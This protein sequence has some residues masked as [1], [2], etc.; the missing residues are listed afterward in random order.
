MPRS[1]HPAVSL[2]TV[3]LTR[4]ESYG[5]SSL[6]NV[7]GKEGHRDHQHTCDKWGARALRAA[8]PRDRLVSE[9]RRWPPTSSLRK[10]GHGTG[11]KRLRSE[12]S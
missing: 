1:S 9:P 4:H 10:S 7:P 2:L 11:W 12:S 6:A 8:R 5:P 3:Q